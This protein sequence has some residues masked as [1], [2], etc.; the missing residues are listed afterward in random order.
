M[1]RFLSILISVAVLLSA[2]TGV[3]P[4][5]AANNVLYNISDYDD[6][7]SFVRADKSEVSGI[8]GK[9]A[10]DTSVKIKLNDESNLTGYFDLSWGSVSAG[11]WTKADY[12]GYL[13]TVFSLMTD[14]KPQYA[15][16]C[17][18]GNST[19]GDDVSESIN[20]N[21]WNKVITISDRTGGENHGKT[22]TY[23]NGS[24]LKSWTDDAF[25]DV[26]NNTSFKYHIRFLVGGTLDMTVYMDDILVYETDTM[27]L[28]G[29][30][31]TDILDGAAGAALYKGS[32]QA[33][34]GVF[35]KLADD[36]CDL[37]T[38]AD[39]TVNDIFYQISWSPKN[40]ASKY[41]VYEVS[42]APGDK[43]S[44]LYIGTNQNSAMSATLNIGLQLAFNRWNKVVM[45]YDIYNATSDL[46]VN[47]DVVSECYPGK[48]TVGSSNCI[49]LIMTGADASAYIDDMRVYEC[50]DYPEICKSEAPE[51]AFD[52]TVGI[53]V[54]NQEGIITVM[55]AKTA[56]QLKAYIGNDCNIRIYTDSTYRTELAD[57]DNV[58]DK[59]VVVI[60][61]NDKI[62]TY[63]NIDI[64]IA[65]NIAFY[66]DMYN[67]SYNTLVNGSLDII[68]PVSDKGAIVA[69]QYNS[70]NELIKLAV[71]KNAVNGYVSTNFEPDRVDNSTV[72]LFL[73]ESMTSL[74]PLCAPKTIE[75]TL[76]TTVCFLGDSITQKGKYIQE[77][78]EY[79]C[80]DETAK[81]GLRM[82]NCGIPG[83]KSADALA[84]IDEDCLSYDPDVTFVM[85]G[86][87]DMQ[88]AYFPLDETA[89]ANAE[90]QREQA[91][92]TYKDNMISIIERLLEYGSKVILMTPVPFDD[93]SDGTTQRNVGIQQCGKIVKELAQQYNLDYIDMYEG[94]KNLKWSDYY[95]TDMVHP[96]ERG[97]HVMAQI[98]LKHYGCVSEVDTGDYIRNFTV[99]NEVRYTHYYN[100]RFVKNIDNSAGF[101]GMTL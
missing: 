58:T 4:A 13:V 9:S 59:C 87:N 47:G 89:F 46:Y 45:I 32:A 97:H 23:L 74:K 1:K 76:G 82:Y 62:Y 56:S 18:D 25:G 78:Y 96:S 53:R 68:A 86:T 99:A 35:G 44:R 11:T 85:L 79:Y 77:V 57:T 67:R 51:D 81:P 50:V 49:R 69:A 98:I 30:A 54:D 70:H 27:P 37:L 101:N 17:T 48:Y 19:V 38:D 92:A 29:D 3:T 71:E 72:K 41:L 73:A 95:Y 65:D 61:S 20:L 33:V 100:Y 26:H 93:V 14:Q 80:T 7:G 90:A 75:Y 94:M 52:T 16:L 24:I 28:I 22:I 21:E 10:D 12:N 2:M 5:F 91:Y 31:V 34:D 83:D 64:N 15:R 66:S 88:K 42:I 39:A 43:L 60:E 8:G 36:G 84:R 63:Y 55:G 40:P 6:F